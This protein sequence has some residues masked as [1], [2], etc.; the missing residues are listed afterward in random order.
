MI[1]DGCNHIK[2]I[3]FHH[4]PYLTDE[5]L[6]DA[7]DKLKHSLTHLELTSCGDIS[8][9]GLS[10][11]TNLRYHLVFICGLWGILTDYK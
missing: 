4:C 10:Y 7:I 8:D 11:V 2:R 3:R 1:A 9:A 6:A 5:A